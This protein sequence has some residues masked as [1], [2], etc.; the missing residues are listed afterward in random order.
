MTV[1]NKFTKRQE[2]KIKEVGRKIE[3]ARL[4]LRLSIREA[5]ERT[6]TTRGHMTEAT[7]RRVERGYTQTSLGEVTYK[8]TALTLA[9]M[10]EVVG[11]DAEVLC[12]EL[13]LVAP[14]APATRQPGSVRERR[15]DELERNLEAAL[16]EVR[17]LR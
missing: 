10:A 14:P 6:H 11:L 16:E 9:A 12:K 4:G 5:A 13:G 8:P 17:R 15:I 7:W 3:N 2:T 1:P